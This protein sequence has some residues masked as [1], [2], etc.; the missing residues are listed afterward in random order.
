MSITAKIPT[1]LN[2]DQQKWTQAEMTNVKRVTIL[3][4]TGR[5]TYH[6]W[7]GTDCDDPEDAEWY[8]TSVYTL[9]MRIELTEEVQL[10]EFEAEVM[11]L[12]DA[13]LSIV[14]DG[15]KMHKMGPF[16]VGRRSQA[17]YQ[18]EIGPFQPSTYSFNHN[19]E[20]MRFR[21]SVVIRNMKSQQDCCIVSP[22]FLIKS[23]KPKKATAIANAMRDPRLA[24]SS[25]D[26]KRPS[27]PTGSEITDAEER[28]YKR[29]LL[30]QLMHSNAINSLVNSSS[31]V[32]ELVL[33]QKMVQ[34]AQLVQQMGMFN[35]GVP[36]SSSNGLPSGQ[37][38]PLTLMPTIPNMAANSSQSQQQ[39]QSF[40]HNQ[41]RPY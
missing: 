33:M 10:E 37:S 26:R 31:S 15:L 18:G 9:C 41:Y 38:Q 12:N 25:L 36:G 30:A 5:T 24:F 16:R 22:S 35:N 7:K 20:H 14:A 23:K 28:S 34:A 19:G 17:M 4:K 13:D 21:L 11:L 2:A 3:S 29:Q 27:S 40:T 32:E 39:P 1:M 8:K 6:P